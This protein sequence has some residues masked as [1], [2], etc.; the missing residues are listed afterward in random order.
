[1][2]DHWTYKEIFLRKMQ[3]KRM[4]NYEP[5]SVKITTRPS[6][7]GTNSICSEEGFP[8]GHLFLF[9]FFPQGQVQIYYAT[10]GMYR[11]HHLI[12][13]GK[14][15]HRYIRHW[16]KYKTSIHLYINLHRSC[17]NELCSHM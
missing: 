7:T 6:G 14:I 11:T 1:M 10:R 12:Y 9:N 15:L 13:D 8:K 16:K 2:F 17:S 5:Q 4:F 3:V